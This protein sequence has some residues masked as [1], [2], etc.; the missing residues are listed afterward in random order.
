MWKLEDCKVAFVGLGLIGILLFA[1]PTL[2]LILHLPNEEKFSELWI[3]G[4]QHMA[5]NYPFNVNAN[6]SYLIYIGVGN[7]MGSSS[8]Y[9]VYV[10]FRNQTEPLPNPTTGTQSPLPILYEYRVFV[11]DGQTWEAPL[12]FSFSNVSFLENKCLVETLTVND[13]TFRV[14]KPALWD[15]NNKGYYYQLFLELWIYDGNAKIFQFHN[16]FAGIWLNATRRI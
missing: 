2:S 10:K 15:A 1:S 6:V 11:Q 8:Y 5:E 16:R 12:T 9:A 3:L 7:H 4:P 13:V 14:D